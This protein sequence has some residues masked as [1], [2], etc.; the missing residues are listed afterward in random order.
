MGGIFM[1]AV[2]TGSLI[3]LISDLMLIFSRHM[4]VESINSLTMFGT[5]STTF[6]GL[7]GGGISINAIST[8]INS[9]KP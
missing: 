4:N 5:L 2:P 7:I 8:W 3:Y 9:H 6:I 1:L